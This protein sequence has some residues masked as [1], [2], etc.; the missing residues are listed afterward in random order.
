[1]GTVGPR[2]SSSLC[3]RTRFTLFSASTRYHPSTVAWWFLDIVVL[4][5]CA[6]HT[7]TDK[8]GLILLTLDLPPPSFSSPLDTVLCFP[9][10]RT[11][12]TSI[13]S[14]FCVAIF[15]I[16]GPASQ[17]RDTLHPRSTFSSNTCKYLPIQP[18]ICVPCQT[19]PPPWT[20]VSAPL[21]TSISAVLETSRLSSL[22]T[23]SALETYITMSSLKDIVDEVDVEPLQYQAA[24]RSTRERAAQ[25]YQ[26]PSD[27]S[28]GSSPSRDPKGKKATRRRRSHHS[29]T[30]HEHYPTL[31]HRAR[32]ESDTIEAM[33]YRTRGYRQASASSTRHS[34]RASDG[35]ES[36]V[37]LTPITRR[38]SRA[39]K[40]IP[41]HVC[42]IC[43]PSKV[44]SSTPKGISVTQLTL[45]RHSP[46]LNT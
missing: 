19:H 26:V 36:H 1:M 29:S 9:S 25:H 7:H 28:P 23:L 20:P 13:F 5:A 2:P 45:D 6:Y 18:V 43:E 37:K 21:A 38:I 32:Q 31:D 24:I 30:D 46:E 12:T 8:V 4:S 33:E 3:R 15:R 39:K 16:P 35:S 44:C 10:G 41:V 27:Q 40:G 22:H 14:S 11:K 42:D 17:S 34:P